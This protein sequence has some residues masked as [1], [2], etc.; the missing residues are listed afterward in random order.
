MG[1]LF[2]TLD[3][4][5]KR[6]IPLRTVSSLCLSIVALLVLLGS[7]QS[8]LA[9]SV[10]VQSPGNGASVGSP[11]TFSASAGSPSGISGWVIYVDD[12][13]KYQVDNDSNS[14]TASVSL[15]GGSHYVYIR[16]WDNT[17]AFGTSPPSPSTS[18]AATP[19]LA[20]ACPL[21]PPTPRCLTRSKNLPAT[22]RTAAIAPV[23]PT[24]ETTG[25][26][27]GR[28]RLPWTVPACRS[29]MAADPGPMSSGSRNSATRTR[30]RTSSG[31]STSTSTPPPPPTC[32]PPS[33]ISGSL[34]AAGNS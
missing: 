18:A 21:R 23:A 29:L 28:P 33:M 32:G 14:L 1:R 9:V 22:G 16:A 5:S 27:S 3:H 12:Q 25:R 13:N 4:S 8:S 26:H 17:G 20:A 6:R 30:R 7:A 15:S 19:V 10:S 24:P 34:S 2:S 11:V 31:T